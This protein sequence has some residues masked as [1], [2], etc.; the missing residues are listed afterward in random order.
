MQRY[1]LFAL[2]AVVVLA[3][4]GPCLAAAASTKSAEPTPS[5]QPTLK[6]VHTLA[7]WA[8]VLAALALVGVVWVGWSLRAL[9]KNQ[10]QLG[11]LIQSQASRKDG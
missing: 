9:A 5:D 3:V 7:R 6:D 2:L 1:I 11:K 10:V 4:A 8:C